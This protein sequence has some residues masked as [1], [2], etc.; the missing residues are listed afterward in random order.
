[1]ST[2]VIALAYIDPK[3]AQNWASLMIQDGRHGKP[4][5]REKK[6]RPRIMRLQD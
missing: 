1:M 2:F 3:K 6:F 5:E 4:V